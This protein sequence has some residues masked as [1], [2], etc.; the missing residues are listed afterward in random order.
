MFPVNDEIFSRQAVS[1]R[2]LWASLPKLGRSP[3]P[4]IK[5]SEVS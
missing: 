2:Q 3:A 1:L 4:E 5:H